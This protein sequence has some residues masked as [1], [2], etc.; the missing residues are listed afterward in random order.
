VGRFGGDAHRRLAR[1][2]ACELSFDASSIHLFD[3]ATGATLRN[4]SR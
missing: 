4:A 3:A 1:G 2:D